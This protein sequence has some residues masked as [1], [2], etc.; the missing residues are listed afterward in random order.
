MSVRNLVL[1]DRIE[2]I[3]QI[4]AVIV[5]VQTSE[6]PKQSLLNDIFGVIFTEL[7]PGKVKQAIVISFEQ[8]LPSRCVTLTNLL[9]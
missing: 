4:P 6:E 2:V 1:G 9:N 8:L 5:V 7:E 3:Q